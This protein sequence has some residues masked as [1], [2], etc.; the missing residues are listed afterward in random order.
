M[1]AP[2]ILQVEENLNDVLLLHRAFWEAGIANPIQISTD[3]QMA[4]DYLSGAGRYADRIKY[5]LPGLVLLDL[6]LAKKS[7]LEVL[8]WIRSQ[9]SLTRVVVIVFTSSQYA[10]DVALAYELGANSFLARPTDAAARLEMAQ[11]LKS[12]LRYNQFAP[13]PE[14][15]WSEPVELPKSYPYYGRRGLGNHLG[16]PV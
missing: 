13:L 10:G 5:P 4:I 9:P 7:G 11:F 8:D 2:C 15:R 14:G 3:G 6:K 1:K 16:G 12:W